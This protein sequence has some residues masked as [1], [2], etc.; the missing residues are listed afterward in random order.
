MI[1][2]VASAAIAARRKG[3]FGEASINIGNSSLLGKKSLVAP[4]GS[5]SPGP[6]VGGEDSHHR[7]LQRIKE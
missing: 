7:E 3:T 4:G 6:A 2:Q 1:G 5:N